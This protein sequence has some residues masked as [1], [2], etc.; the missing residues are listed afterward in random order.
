M[1][2]ASHCPY[3]NC[4]QHL[5][6]E[7][8][9]CKRY[10]YYYPKCRPRPIP[11]FRCHS[12]N[13]TFSRQTFRADY[14]DHRPDLNAPLFKL[15]ASGMGIRQ[16]ARVLGLSRSCTEL[17]L[18]KIARHLRRLNL[19]LRGQLDRNSTLHFDEIETFEGGR[20]TRP[21]TVPVLIETKSRYILWSES[22]TIRPRGKMTPKRLKLIAIAEERHGVR[23]DRS[24]RGIERTLQRAVELAAQ[25]PMVTFFSDEKST[26]PG[27]AK[28]AFGADRLEHH[29]TNSKV[30]RDTWNPLFPINHEEAVMRDLMG[31]LRRDSWLASKKRRYLDLGLQVHMAYR[32]LVRRRFNTDGD[33]ESPAQLLGFLPRRLEFGEALSWRQDWGERSI[34]PLS[35]SSGTIKWWATS[36]ARAA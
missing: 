30:L 3:R 31:R 27:L 32:N 18:R 9:F 36:S 20:N 14:R 11:R 2:K 10:G 17:K 16:C 26:Y 23:K 15:I 21:L 4:S 24:R 28:K 33:K 29:K 19:N 1:F 25:M 13:R 6:P 7:P 8:G 12:C 34:H 22:A 35:R 5:N